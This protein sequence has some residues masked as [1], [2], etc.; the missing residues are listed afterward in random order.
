MGDSVSGYEKGGEEA[1]LGGSRTGGMQNLV[2]GLWPN[3]RH[4]DRVAVQSCNTIK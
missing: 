1:W 4:M 2:L 3:M